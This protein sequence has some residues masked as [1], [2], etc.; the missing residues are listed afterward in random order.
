MKT[1]FWLSV[2]VVVYVYA[3]Y[4]LFLGMW[5]AA[6]RRFARHRN[7]VGPDAA[8]P[9]NDAR[10]P[11]VSVLLAVRNEA[12][13]LPARLENLLALDY[14]PDRLEIVVMSNGSTDDTASLL[15]RY[16]DRVVTR[17]LGV[18]G[19][20]GA[21]NAA[22]AASAND[23]LIFADARQR[24]APDAIRRLVEPFADPAVG[25]VTGELVL[26]SERPPGTGSDAAGS[27]VGEG[28]GL[29]WRYEK[30]LRRHESEVHSVLGA[31]GA[32]YALRKS[33]WRPLPLDTLLDDVLAPMRAVLEGRRIVFAPGARAFDQASPDAATERRRKQR[34]LAGNYQLLWLEPRLLVPGAN[35]VWLQFVSHKV[36]RLLVPY[37]LVALAVSN[38]AIAPAS[39]VYG[40]ALALQVAFYLLAVH[41]AFVVAD[42]ERTPVGDGRPI[43]PASAPPR[44]DASAGAGAVRK[45]LA[46]A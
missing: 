45:D 12:A 6:R 5:A 17:S 29:Y 34:T 3:G 26:D 43:A 44:H 25:G 28:V 31:T 36:G 14:P 37:A 9:R 22:V 33:L 15:S 2:A 24:F 13:R 18:V 10:L 4:P 21:L 11:G 42:A 7:A 40:V 38:A 35:P 23:I 46:N 30:W 20:A 8:A 41:G 16:A 27:T 1:V 39:A 19:K 32:I